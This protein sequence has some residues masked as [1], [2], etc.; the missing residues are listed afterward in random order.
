MNEVD[1]TAARIAAGLIAGLAA[2][3][4]SAVPS[5]IVMDV[6]RAAAAK[7]ATGARVIH[8]EVG[9]PSTPAPQLARDAAKRAIDSQ[10]LGYTQAL[11]NDALRARIAQFYLDTYG[12]RV[13]ESRIVVTAGSSAAFVLAFLA[14]LDPGSAML[15]PNPSYPCYRHILAALGN[16]SVL[17]ETGPATRWMPEPEQVAAAAVAS[18]AK[19]LLI[20]S[21]ANPTGTMIEPDRLAALVAV[22][23]QHGL[24]FVSDEIYHGLTYDRSAQTAL[25]VSDDAIVI[26]SFSKYFSMTGWRVGW[27]VVPERLVRPIEKLAQNFYISPPAI[28]QVAALA[29][30]D[31]E[32]ELDANRARYAANRAILLAELPEAGFTA[33]APADGAFYLYADISDLTSDSLAFARRMLEEI[34]VA[35]TPGVD[36]DAARGHQFLR[37]SYAGATADMAEAA[38]RLIAWKR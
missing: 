30:F 10:T 16:P 26:N 38:Q 37:F 24:W 12:V 20:A 28:A 14:T 4:R 3:G 11:G 22:C 32:V 18:R 29:A 13:A 34:G 23:A 19:A 35:A 27:M 1:T 21:P 17:V 7:E 2:S 6:M 9:Q 31:A 5:F 15:L 25:A 8:M 36:F 33:F